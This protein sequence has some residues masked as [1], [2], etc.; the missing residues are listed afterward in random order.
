MGSYFLYYE[1]AYNVSTRYFFIK[2][3]KLNQ[4]VKAFR[5][6]LYFSIF[7][8]SVEDV[9]HGYMP[10]VNKVHQLKVTGIINGVEKID[11]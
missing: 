3:V 1:N 8:N 5:R 2:G 4:L 10:H 6:V 11:E 7:G 9:I